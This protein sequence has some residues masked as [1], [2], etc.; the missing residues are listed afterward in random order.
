MH[1]NFFDVSKVNFLIWL[2][3]LEKS[4]LSKHLNRNS[5]VWQ[6][7]AL[8]D[9]KSVLMFFVVVEKP[10]QNKFIDICARK[11]LVSEKLKERFFFLNF[12]LSNFIIFCDE[13]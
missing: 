3:P 9:S 2:A 6:K 10:F 1:A 12:F 11:K 4:N 7:L 13:A 5:K 8:I